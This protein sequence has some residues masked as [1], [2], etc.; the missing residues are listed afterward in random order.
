MF[1]RSTKKSVPIIANPTDGFEQAAIEERMA[2]LNKLFNDQ[3]AQRLEEGYK[4]ACPDYAKQQ[5][6]VEENVV[7]EAR[8]RAE[9]ES[10]DMLKKAATDAYFVREKAKDEARKKIFDAETE[11]RLICDKAKE[12]ARLI[13]DKASKEAREM[14]EKTTEKAK[15]L[16][17]FA[18][19]QSQVARK[20]FEASQT[21][22]PVGEGEKKQDDIA[23]KRAKTQ[24]GDM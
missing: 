12:D 16:F 20:H 21:K 22:R 7:E 6:L 5:K 10:K 13:R 8:K 15:R 9:L 4:Q 2:T 11:A 24:V 18:Q 23:L 3:L 1:F 19:Q 17:A 14:I